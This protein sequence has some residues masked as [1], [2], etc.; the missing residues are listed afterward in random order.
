[1]HLHLL[2]A[3]KTP[4]EEEPQLGW[5]SKSTCHRCRYMITLWLLA[6]CLNRDFCDYDDGLD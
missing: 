6:N 3:E 1:M 2:S 5:V 4:V